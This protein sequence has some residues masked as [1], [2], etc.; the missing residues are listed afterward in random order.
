MEH[1]CDALTNKE[2]RCKRIGKWTIPNIIHGTG[3]GKCDWR[4]GRSVHLCRQHHKPFGSPQK[5][6]VTLIE[7][8]FLQPYNKYKYG[9]IVL[10]GI[11]DWNNPPDI[12][13]APKY[14]MEINEG[15]AS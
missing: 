3:I 8:G 2:N 6:P 12:A 11:I 9:S 4:Y 1:Q 14:W 10:C 5:I 13:E 15:T 7:D